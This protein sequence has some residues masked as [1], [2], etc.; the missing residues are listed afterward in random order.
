MTAI[1]PALASALLGLAIGLI[2]GL[3]SRIGRFCTLGALE[4]ALY[5]G[6]FV[7]LRQWGVAIGV[8][9]ILNHLA[10]SQGLIDTGGTLYLGQVWYPLGSVL[11]GL[12]FGYGMAMAGNCG[13]G[14]LARLG[15]GDLRSLMIVLVMGMTAYATLSGPLAAWR[16]ALMP[17]T[18]PPPSPPGIAQDLSRLGGAPWIWGVGIGALVLALALASRSAR[19]A[20]AKMGWGAAVGAAVALAFVGTSWLAYTSFDAVPVVAPTFASPVGETMIWVM[21]AS[22]Q[23]LSFAVGCVSGV[24]VGALIGSVRKGHFRWEVCDDA[25]ELGRLIAGATMM[26]IGGVV[27]AGCSV[28]QGLSGLSLL[29]WSG[30]VTLAAICAGAALGLRR[31]IIAGH[32]V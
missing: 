32:G 24:V 28:G 5:G 19:A 30:P 18:A 27:A 2:L 16:V 3:A 11:G 10:L 17:Q 15:G 9:M 26:G 23:S 25:R 12:L 14:A 20:P 7:R 1:D 29:A 8:A 4:D 13:F 22:G 6:S 21:T 31:L